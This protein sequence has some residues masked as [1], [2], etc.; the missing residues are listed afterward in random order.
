MRGRVTASDSGAVSHATVL[1]V[2]TQ[3]RATADDSGGYV[4]RGVPPGTYT[5]RVRLL[6]Y[7]P[8]SVTA[9][10][11]RGGTVQQDFA[12]EAQPISLSPIDVTVGSRAQHTAAEEL[13]VPVDVLPAELI[14]Q[15]GTTETSQIIQQL[16]PSVNF[17]HQSV[18]D[19]TDIVRPFTMR[20]LG[21][22]Q[23]L[24]LVNGKRR[25][26]MA[27]V[28]VYGAALGA[29]SSGVDLNALPSS[30]FERIEVLRDGAAAQYGSDAIAGVLNMVLKEGPFP[31]ILTAD[32]GGYT[33]IDFPADGRT[34]NFT[35]GWGLNVGRGSLALFGEFRDR[36]ATNRA[37]PDPVDQIVAGDHDSIVARRI[38]V[39]RNAVPQPNH[40]WGDGASRDYLSF[41]NLKYPLTPTGAPSSTP[42]AATAT[43]AAPATASGARRS[44]PATGPRST[45]WA[46]SPS[47]I[48][49]SR[50]TRATPACGARRT[51]G[52][53]TPPPPSATTSSA[54]T[55]GTR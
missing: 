11:T 13:A 40:H 4:I 36:D 55:S 8:Q 54:T 24:V 46:S 44:T 1:I 21:P 33:P 47:S 10:V 28:H 5:L 9:T 53:T 49:R 22:D 51:A 19:A 18:A 34:M 45:R 31:A 52:P 25:H 43:A 16:A 2:G 41:A 23:S 42:S 12:M 32:V 20:G 37:G 35:G 17:P 15:Q 50:T 3:F 27:L 29:G 6:G 38:I 30:A 39:K 14:Q 26:R 7:V 48:R